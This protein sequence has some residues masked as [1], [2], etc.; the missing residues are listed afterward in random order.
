L[1]YLAGSLLLWFTA[2][3]WTST[4]P[5]ENE[6]SPYIFKLAISTIGINAVFYQLGI[7]LRFKR[8]TNVFALSNFLHAILNILL[9]FVFVS[10]FKLGIDAIYYA[11][12]LVAPVIV[13]F[14]WIAVRKDYLPVIG[15]AETARLLKFSIPLIPTALA[16]IVLELTDRL[17]IAEYWSLKEVGIYG[18]GAKF[19]SI[20]YLVITGFSMALGPII[21]E[22]HTLDSTKQ[23]LRK[24]IRFYFLAGSV[25][26]L[27][28]AMFSYETLL[29]FTNADYFGASGVMPFL[30]VSVFFT[31]IGMFSVGVH[32]SGKTYIS[33]LIVMFSALLN[34][35]LNYLFIP[36][37]GFV[38]AGFSTMISLWVNHVVYYLISSRYYFFFSASRVI[39]NT[40]ILL[41]LALAL[42]LSER[43]D[44]YYPVV[45]TVK[46]LIAV[47]ALSITFVFYKKLRRSA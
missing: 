20:L 37:Y 15:R 45:L 10:Q 21:Y 3:F 28:L 6:I 8:K 47:A 16:Y 4:L 34:L 23:K 9:T 13:L 42:V 44:L 12:I 36:D 39:L 29:V 38:G 31:G 19:S 33:S 41:I 27:I 43:L 18:V 22:N 26:V 17:I 5:S 11:S 35:G 2:P 7:H 46:I 40:T 1:F 24:L 32:L 14:Q 30:Y 25:S